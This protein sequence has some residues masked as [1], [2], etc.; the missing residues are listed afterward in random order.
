M[1]DYNN[2]PAFTNSSQPTAYYPTIGN[3]NTP[4]NPAFRNQMLLRMAQAAAMRREPSS[5]S[6]YQNNQDN[7]NG[8]N[9]G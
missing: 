5:A 3:P 6:V 8:A 7:P 1:A 4:N 2:Q 9:N